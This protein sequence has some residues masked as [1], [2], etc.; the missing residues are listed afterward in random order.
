VCNLK[1]LES[2][3]FLNVQNLLLYSWLPE[4]VYITGPDFNVN[5][6]GLLIGMIISEGV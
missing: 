3:R 4:V 6:S 2:N 5:R 1:H